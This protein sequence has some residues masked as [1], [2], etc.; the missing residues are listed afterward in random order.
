MG[1]GFKTTEEI[2]KLLLTS[3]QLPHLNRM[4]RVSNN[5]K[6]SQI[7]GVSEISVNLYH[8]PPPPRWYLHLVVVE[9]F[10][11]SSNPES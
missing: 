8:N 2:T 5:D 6:I 1:D 4:G 10:V 11:S 3:S 7:G 9:G